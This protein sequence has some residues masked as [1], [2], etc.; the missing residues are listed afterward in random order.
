[1]MTLNR[2][3]DGIYF[4]VERDGIWQSIC[5]SDLTE[6]EF[7][8]VMENKNRNFA[9]SCCKILARKLREIGDQFDIINEFENEVD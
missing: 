7:D 1:M 3:L 5:L 4:R 8:R 2:G 9:V 6:E